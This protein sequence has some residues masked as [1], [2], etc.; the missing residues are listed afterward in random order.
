[1]PIESL[2]TQ[3]EHKVRAVNKHLI[4]EVACKERDG[5]THHLVLDTGSPVSF[6]YNIWGVSRD[7]LSAFIGHDVSGLIGMDVMEELVVQLKMPKD[8]EDGTIT[9][10]RPLYKGKV[11]V[12]V[13][14]D[15]VFPINLNA[16]VPTVMAMDGNGNRFQAAVDTG[17]RVQYLSRAIHETF[18]EKRQYRGLEP[19]F[20]PLFGKFETT[21]M[22]TPI[23]VEGLNMTLAFGQLPKPL[24]SIM[25]IWGVEGI[26]GYEFLD[27]FDEVVFDFPN[28]E[29]ICNAR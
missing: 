21:T 7:E 25:S 4:V 11:P 14:G 8:G 16:M 9:F 17:A 23:C 20:F 13:P 1:M 18:I 19:D 15:Y 28:E 6:P 3:S 2:L 26:L 24:E 22:A 29:L 10:A 27:S 5:H 12:V